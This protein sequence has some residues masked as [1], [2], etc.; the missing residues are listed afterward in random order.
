MS[1][2]RDDSKG[3][4]F[5]DLSEDQL[6]PDLTKAYAGVKALTEA[7]PHNIAAWKLGGTTPLTQDIFK[8][9]DL[10]FG[11]IYSHETFCSGMTVSLPLT[12]CKVELEIAVR[13]GS[14]GPDAWAVCAEMPSSGIRDLPGKGVTAL[15]AD[16]CAAGAL[17]IGPTQPINSIDDAPKTGVN[18]ISDGQVITSGGTDGLTDTPLSIA[19]RFCDI[20]HREGFAP[21]AGQWIATGGM[22]PCVQVVRQGQYSVPGSFGFDFHLDLP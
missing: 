10:Y 12:E 16:R 11:P 18:L 17:I 7:S 15:V 19:H 9:S 13:H 3:P 8:V 21:K 5:F 20:A 4:G 6:W 1:Y 2:V 14:S 22:S